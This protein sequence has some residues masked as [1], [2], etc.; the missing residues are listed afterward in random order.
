MGYDRRTGRQ[1]AVK[2]VDKKRY[3]EEDQSFIREINCLCQVNHPCCVKLH[4]VYVTQR[5]VYIVTELVSGGELLD[6]VTELGRLTDSAAAEV[7]VQILSCAAYLH[8]TGICSRDLK[9]E[10]ILMVDK[11]SNH[12]K[13][14]DFGLSRFFDRT[15]CDPLSTMCGSPQYVAPE[16]LEL[17]DSNRT[18]YSEAVDMW[19]AGVIIFILLAG[20]APFDDDNDVALY[21]KIR[22]GEHDMGDPVWD[23]ISP[24]ARDLV[25]KL[26]VVDP[27]SRLSAQQA[28]L[29]PWLQTTLGPHPA[30][31]PLQ[32]LSNCQSH[33]FPCK[34]IC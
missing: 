3:K 14:I 13:I 27:A 6:R 26:L 33:L 15:A 5:R 34:E 10:N 25:E 17:A 19:S 28:L 2:I 12:V 8:A 4:A 11:E 23:T 21:Q 31:A 1:V 9:L 29:H 22:R 32:K 18:G 24:L 30:I 16:I 7:A 20:Y